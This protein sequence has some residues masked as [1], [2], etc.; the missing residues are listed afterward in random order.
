MAT[1]AVAI[2]LNPTTDTTGHTHP[3]ATKPGIPNTQMAIIPTANTDAFTSHSTH[4][5][6]TTSRAHTATHSPSKALGRLARP[7]GAGE[8]RRAYEQQ[9]ADVSLFQVIEI[10]DRDPQT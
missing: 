8:R 10:S 4:Q 7:L 2:K 5:G 6:A 1:I 3:V 9:V